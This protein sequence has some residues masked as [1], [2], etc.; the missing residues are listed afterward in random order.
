M[1][2]LPKL[3]NKKIDIYTRKK[4]N[5]FSCIQRKKN[6]NRDHDGRNIQDYADL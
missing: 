3:I 6:S 2:S 4:K 5:Y 1:L